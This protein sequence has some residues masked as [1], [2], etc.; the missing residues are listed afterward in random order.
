MAHGAGLAAIWGSWARYVYEAHAERFAQFAVQV[1]G[2][3][4]DTDLKVTA[5]KGIEAMERFYRY[6]DMPTSV[7][8]L[9]VDLTDEQIDELALKCSFG[10]TRTIGVI[11]KLGLED[12]KKIYQ[13]AR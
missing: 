13:M 1:F 7:H 5:L 9:G 10:N 3:E 12:I 11:K 2:I 4:C 8:E 6:I